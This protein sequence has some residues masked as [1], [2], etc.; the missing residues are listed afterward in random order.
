MER[1]NAK[2]SNI[3]SW[4]TPQFHEDR[5][6]LVR[7]TKRIV[8]ILKSWNFERFDQMFLIVRFEQ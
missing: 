8:N 3:I 5:P 1:R 2:K 4:S 6:P 7:V